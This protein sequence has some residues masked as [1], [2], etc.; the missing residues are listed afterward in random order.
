[1]TQRTL[2]RSLAMVVALAALS[3]LVFAHDC[4]S[5]ATQHQPSLSASVLN[6]Q[7]R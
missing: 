3:T 7:G 6:P 5:G 1:M 2:T 4:P